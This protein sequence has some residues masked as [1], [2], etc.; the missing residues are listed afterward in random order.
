MSSPYEAIPAIR[1]DDALVE[2]AAK[3]ERPP[4]P[5]REPAHAETPEDH[6]LAVSNAELAAALACFQQVFAPE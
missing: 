3:R 6:D 4:T 1:K 5:L 2:K